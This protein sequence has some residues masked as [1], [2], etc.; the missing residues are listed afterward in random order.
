LFSDRIGESPASE[1]G[2]LFEL[3][4]VPD[5]DPA[6][7]SV[8]AAPSSPPLPV[9]GAASRRALSSGS[10][11][12]VPDGVSASGSLGTRFAPKAEAVDPTAT[13]R[14]MTT[15]V[16]ERPIGD[17]DTHTVGSSA[18]QRSDLPGV[19]AVGVLG[20]LLL[21]ATW[22]EGA[23]ALRHWAPVAILGLVAVATALVAGG[24]S[25]RGRAA[26]VAVA[27]IW[28]FAAW[29]LLSTLWAESAGRALE[30][31]G[32]TLLYAALFT[33][34]IAAPVR[35]R[36]AAGLGLAVVGGVVAVAAITLVELLG[37]G[38][39]EFLAGRLDDPVGYRNATACL[40]ALAFW[41]LV[42]TAAHRVGNPVLRAAACGGAALVVALA[43]L[44]QARG[45]LLGLALGGVVAI[46]LGPDRVRRLWVALL[47]VAGVAL[48]S[49]DLLTPYRA[50]TDGGPEIAADIAVAVDAV[51]LLTVGATILGLAAAL[52][53]GGLRLSTDARA[54]AR[55]VAIA[56]LVLL[57]PVAIAVTLAETGNPVT[58]AQDRFDEFRSLETAAPGET[59]LAFGGG[60]RSDIWRVALLELSDH[61]LTGVG[62]G[63]YP[64][65][66]YVE[67]RTDRNLSTPHSLP[68]E[69]LAEKGLV[70][71]LAFLAFLVAI[72]AAVGRRWRAADPPTRW[73][74][75]GLLAGAAVVFGQSTVDWIWLIPGLMGLAFLLLGLGVAALAPGNELV[76][77]PSA[78]RP[79][80]VAAGALVALT[81]IGV[82]LLYVSD[83]DVRRARDPDATAA[84][85]LSAAREAERLNRWSMV[86][87]YLQAGALEELGRG[88][89]AR[90]ELLDARELEPAN[91]ATLGLLGDLELRRGNERA[92]RRWY[93]R[94]LALN[95]LDVGLRK[96]ARGQGS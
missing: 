69:L 30:G 5:P 12:T 14:Q 36:T 15:N 88:R 51:V 37:G 11:Y 94:A 67:R 53:D 64:F 6:P 26:Q 60:Q 75:S 52:L 3:P 23:F 19:V 61:P 65:D 80:R 28:A 27:A 16:Y 17:D 82:M 76:R 47:I 70:G 74:A 9:R 92:A 66:Y 18:P 68:F 20:L 78:G 50:F 7:A 79:L 96:L 81:A 57:V 56:G 85:R 63:N 21:V 54:V 89:E 46:A 40:F 31:S 39:A 8:P 55:R 87:R 29:V 13:D 41:P 25:V 42:A 73:A 72:V 49:D 32:R 33:V 59:R 91:F 86:P 71:V 44:T 10:W 38:T 1:L 4:P 34:A 84:E 83:A 24:L 62:E 45:V 93:R 48:L 95:P 22:F 58:F 77:S 2:A 35:G 43:L 90:R